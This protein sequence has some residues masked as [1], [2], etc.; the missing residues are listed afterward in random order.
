[1]QV[2]EVALNR[3][4]YEKSSDIVR[5]MRDAGVHLLAG[6]DTGAPFLFPGSVLH[7]E[8]ALLVSAGLTP[9][10]ALQSATKNPA[11]FLGQSQ[12]AGTIERGKFAD[13]LLL[14]A[15]PLDDIHNTRKISGVIVRGRLLNL[16]DL[17]ALLS[18][19]AKFAAA[20]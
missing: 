3:A 10:E 15:N 16:R 13:L 6:T 18:S 4:L 17:D 9:M 19:V 20:N 14:D 1:M 12:L 7:D 5:Q 11:D 2:G 8:L